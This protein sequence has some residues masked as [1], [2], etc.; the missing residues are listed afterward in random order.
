MID[1]VYSLSR[2]SWWRITI[3]FSS[4]ESIVYCPICANKSFSSVEHR[5]RHR[6]E[7]WWKNCKFHI[8]NCAQQKKIYAM[9]SKNKNWWVQKRSVKNQQN[10]KL[11]N[12]K[13]QRNWHLYKDF[14]VCHR[15]YRHLYSK[16]AAFT[17]AQKLLEMRY[18]YSRKRDFLFVKNLDFFHQIGQR[19]EEIMQLWKR[20]SYSL[21]KS[22]LCRYLYQRQSENS[23]PLE[24]WLFV[25]N[26]A[27]HC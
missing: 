8:V 5:R 9:A 16:C 19:Y 22:Q 13:N 10:S 25:R 7:W 2:N 17:S 1:Q 20:K 18:G 26:R 3:M 15:Q 24:V 4:F 12:K 27:M 23:A 14:R 21:H 6:I 11:N